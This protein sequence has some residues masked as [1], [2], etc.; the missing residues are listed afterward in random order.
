MSSSNFDLRR[1]GRRKRQS[2]TRGEHQNL[3]G[4]QK[5]IY[6]DKVINV[7]N[8]R[9]PRVY[10]EEN[11]LRYVANGEIG[12][13]VGEFRGKSWKLKRGPRHLEVEFSTQGGHAY[14]FWS[15]EF[16]EETEPPLELA[17]AITVHK[18]QGS[19]F[20]TVFLIIPGEVPN[21]KS[22]VALHSPDASSA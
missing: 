18:S 22:R 9:R 14:T 13:V 11:A 12:I 6:G 5:I 21:P 4:T 2:L 20:G 8:M 17:Y 15:N 7:R 19:E 1:S 3:I 10:P 16:G